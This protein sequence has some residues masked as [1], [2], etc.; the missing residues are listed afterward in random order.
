ML[1]CYLLAILS[2]HIL[3]SL[4]SSFY[5]GRAFAKMKIHSEDSTIALEGDYVELLYTINKPSLN[6]YDYNLHFMIVPPTNGSLIT[7]AI[8]SV[9]CDLLLTITNKTEQFTNSLADS[10]TSPFP[11]KQYFD[12]CSKYSTGICILDQYIYQAKSR[13]SVI[14]YRITLDS[15]V[16][17]ETQIWIVAYDNVNDFQQFLNGSSPSKAVKKIRVNENNFLF[18][19]N[20]EEMKRSAYYFFAV[21]KINGSSQ[22]FTVNHIGY[23]VYYNASKLS[24]NCTI[25][26]TSKYSCQIKATSNQCLLGR[27]HGNVSNSSDPLSD[28]LYHIN[29]A[30]TYATAIDDAL[31][32]FGSIIL[33]ILMVILFHFCTLHCLR[34]F[35]E[36][37]DLVGKV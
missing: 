21:Q 5:N 25:K 6:I 11:T 10:A 22:W 23:H 15:Y 36:K 31:I 13:V 17:G 16:S 14:I 28:R 27:V 35:S 3:I 32:V 18:V 33:L 19:I 37:L 20:N 29:G 9:P 30:M 4:S 12:S 8:Y 2:N 26:N 34:S 1:C 24:P 7:A